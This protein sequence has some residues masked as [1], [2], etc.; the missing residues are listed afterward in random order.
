MS[1]SDAYVASRDAPSGVGG[2]LLFFVLTMVLFGPVFQIAAFLRSYHHTIE[3][4]AQTTHPLGHYLFYIVEQLAG[5]ALYGY[6]IFAPALENPG[7]GA[8]ARKAFPVANRSVSL[9][10]FCNDVERCMDF[11]SARYYGQVSARRTSAT[12]A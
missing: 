1:N 4:F 11:G 8:N 7:P 12:I 5:A 10:G 6:G 9:G 2:W 3:V